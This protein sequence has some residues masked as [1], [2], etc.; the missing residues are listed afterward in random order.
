MRRRVN[1]TAERPTSPCA[2]LKYW[3]SEDYSTVADWDGG[4]C[5]GRLLV[6]NYVKMNMTST[7]S[8]SLIWSVYNTL[9]YHGVRWR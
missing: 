8:W 1:E 7:V 3:S 9:P 6:D 5:W 2:G 4:G